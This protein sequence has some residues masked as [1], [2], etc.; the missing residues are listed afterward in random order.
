MRRW[1][2]LLRPSWL[3][4]F[5]VVVAFAYLCFTVLAPWQLGKNTK[6]SRENAQIANSLTAEPVPVESLLP[7]QDSTAPDEQWRRV[8]AEGRYLPEGQVLARLRMVEGEPAFEVLVPFA[9][10]GGP[11]VLVDR[12]YVRPVEA[13]GVPEIPPVPAETVTIAARLRDS[14]SVA[15]GKEPFR[16]DGVQ[17]VY[18][19]NTEQISAITGVPLAGSYLQLEPEQPGGLGSIPLPHLDAGPFL[20]YGIQWIAF[21]II[22]PIGLGY[23]VYA[24]LRQRRREKAAQEAAQAA[25][26]A[27]LTAEDKLADRYGRRR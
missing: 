21:G 8:T 6:T 13:S 1:T 27:P 11:T 18:S 15:Q 5:V 22:A 26:D 19:I 4:L 3:A 23:F 12:G 2:F 17:Q 24:E 7:Q 20:S 14:E 10:D 9:V 25:P 16:Q